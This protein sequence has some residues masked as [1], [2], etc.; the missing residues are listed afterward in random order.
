MTIE[1]IGQEYHARGFNCCQSVLCTLGSYTG[2]PEDTAAAIGSGFGGG[3][4]CGN[5]CGAV[6]GGLMAIGKSC[7][8]GTAPGEEKPTAVKLARELEARFKDKTGTLLCREILAANGH[9]ICDECIAHAAKEAEKIIREFKG[10][11]EK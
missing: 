2:L 11:E 6:T 10:L 3:M 9:A 4:Q 1:E 5:V 7:F 8:P